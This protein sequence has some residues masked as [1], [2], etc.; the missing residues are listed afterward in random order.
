MYRAYVTEKPI[1]GRNLCAQALQAVEI[2]AL[3][4]LAQYL[5]LAAGEPCYGRR[6]YAAMNIQNSANLLREA[7]FNLAPSPDLAASMSE[8]YN[9]MNRVVNPADWAVFAPMFMKSTS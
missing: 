9:R 1:V 3:G 6:N 2:G 4:I 8:I 7:G 5:Y